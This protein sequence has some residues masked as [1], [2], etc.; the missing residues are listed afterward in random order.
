MGWFGLLDTQQ[1]KHPGWCRIVGG[2]VALFVLCE[3]GYVK[4]KLVWGGNKIRPLRACLPLAYDALACD[5]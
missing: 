4:V 5:G 1:I 2:V 3:N